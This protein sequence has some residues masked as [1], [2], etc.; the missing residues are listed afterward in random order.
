VPC[1]I[2]FRVEESEAQRIIRA[3]FVQQPKIAKELSLGAAQRLGGQ[4][5][6]LLAHVGLEERAKA[7]AG[8]L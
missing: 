2:S 3:A 7:D 4:R 1:Q 8:A 6:E 5:G